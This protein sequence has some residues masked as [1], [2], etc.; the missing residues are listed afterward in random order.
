MSTV[1]A[2]PIKPEYGPTLGRLLS[3]RWRTVPR[4][5]QGAVLVIIALALAGAIGLALTLENAHYTQGGTVPFGFSY[6]GL[7]RTTPEP[8]GY[9]RVWRRE[10]DGRLR[11]SYA[12]G[13]LTIPRYSGLVNGA[14]PVYASQTLPALEARFQSFKLRGVGKTRV[15]G[16]GGYE[17]LFSAHREGQ[18]LLG[19]YVLLLP[20]KPAVVHGVTILMLAAPEPGS[21]TDTPLEVASSGE[22]LLPLKTFTFR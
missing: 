11:Y 21:Q 3:P 18:E 15:N 10:A 5:L 16:V 13:P 19:R 7:Y 12:V 20:E 6:R 8:G 14:L 22:L 1:A 4:G 9:V 2:V 17:V